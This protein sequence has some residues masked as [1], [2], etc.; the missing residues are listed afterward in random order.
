MPLFDVGSPAFQ[1]PTTVGTSSGARIWSGTNTALVNANPTAI[2]VRDL[3]VQNTG[4]AVIYVSTPNAPLVTGGTIQGMAV[5]P[6]GQL[7]LQG[8]TA[9][10]NTTTNDV[11]A[12]GYFPTGASIAVAGLGTLISA[13]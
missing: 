10:T 5:Q 8:W 11:F 6:G 7:T 4:T 13:V 9:V 1:G 3:I 2:T 12:A